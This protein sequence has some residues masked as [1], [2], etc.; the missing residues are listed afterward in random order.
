MH[1]SR[2]VKAPPVEEALQ[3]YVA[4]EGQFIEAIEAGIADLEAGHL[5][6]HELVAAA[7]DRVFRL[8][9]RLPQHGC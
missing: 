9:R 2:D 8:A 1:D 5:L 3:S 7:V 6:S 4:S